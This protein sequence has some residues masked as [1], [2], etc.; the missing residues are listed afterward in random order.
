MLLEARHEQ[1]CTLQSS[2]V[3]VYVHINR[4]AFEALARGSA[5]ASVQNVFSLTL[6]EFN[7]IIS[8]NWGPATIYKYYQSGLVGTL[9]FS[10]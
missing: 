3:S 6:S 5:G 4:T 9:E 1:L 8:K 7:S 10:Y 2:V